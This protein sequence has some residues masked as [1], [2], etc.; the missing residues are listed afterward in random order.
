MDFPGILSRGIGG[1]LDILDSKIHEEPENHFYQAGKII[2][3][4][5]RTIF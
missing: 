4:P 2:F 3:A 5:C 1:Y